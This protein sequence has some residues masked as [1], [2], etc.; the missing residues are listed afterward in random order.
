MFSPSFDYDDLEE[1]AYAYAWQEQDDAIE[2]IEDDIYSHPSLTV[3][4][5]NAI[6]SRS[7]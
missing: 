3:E 2:E 5:R 4:E 7:V 6:L 1:P